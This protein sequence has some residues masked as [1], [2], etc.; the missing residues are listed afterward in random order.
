MNYCWC[1][2]TKQKER[3]WVKTSGMGRRLIYLDRNGEDFTWYDMRD[4]N[5]I[6]E[7]ENEK[8]MK[9]VHRHIRGNL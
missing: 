1:E 7:N 4:E 6:V 2:F 8:Y 5:D 3:Y 9:Q